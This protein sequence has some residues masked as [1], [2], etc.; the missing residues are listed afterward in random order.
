[1]TIRFFRRLKKSDRGASLIEFALILPFLLALVLGIIEFGWIYTGYISVTGAAR[2]GA[3]LAARGEKESVIATRVENH[4]DNF[5]IIQ[6]GEITSSVLTPGYPDG[7]E[8]GGEIA[9]QVIGE[10]PLL[11]NFIGGEDSIIPFPAISNDGKITLRAEATMRREY[12]EP[13]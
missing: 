8:I 13:Q 9:V 3:R 10:L 12:L 5:T 2:E 4:A 11:I 6:G 1:M 7:I